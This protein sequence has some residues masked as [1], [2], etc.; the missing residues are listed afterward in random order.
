MITIQELKEIQ[1][2]LH[3]IRYMTANPVTGKQQALKVGDQLENSFDWEDGNSLH[4]SDGVSALNIGEISHFDLDDEEDAQ[5]ALKLINERLDRLAMYKAQD[6]GNG[7]V[8][9]CGAGYHSYEGNDLDE[10][11]ICGNP[12]ILYIFKAA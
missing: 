5:E 8:V 6:G 9:I 2:D 1:N 12:E 3:G 4:E 10:T 11:V 7:Q